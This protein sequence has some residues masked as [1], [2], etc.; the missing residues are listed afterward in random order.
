MNY[1][2]VPPWQLGQDQEREV[3]S[4]VQSL[5]T[6][7]LARQLAGQRGLHAITP[8][9]YRWG[10]YRSGGIPSEDVPPLRFTDGPRGVNLGRSTALP[11]ASTR[12][13]ARDPAL[14]ER[15]GEAIGAEARAQGATA[16]GSACINLI[17]HPA[18][19]REQES[20]GSDPDHVG[21]L[22]AAHVRG[23]RRHVLPVVK[24]FALNSIE[25]SRFFVDVRVGESTLREVYLPHFFH[26][27]AA[28]AGAVMTA[29]K[30]VNGTY[31]VENAALLH[32]LRERMG[33]GARGVDVA[34]GPARDP[35][36]LGRRPA[37]VARTRAAARM[38]KPTQERRREGP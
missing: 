6:A 18:W 30:K 8:W 23:L 4:L 36:L 31:C 22:G 16:V 35:R 21:Q 37:R 14:E 1:R 24:H 13:A 26:T 7:G 9:T 2:P 20:L 32:I 19:G 33:F 10:A 3:A 25:N 38:T 17:R 34:R 15:V 29:H 5:S 12:G 28:G 11:S 27:V